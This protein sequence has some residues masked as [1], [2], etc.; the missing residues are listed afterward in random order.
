MRQIV[1]R[2]IALGIIT[3]WAV[4]TI[5]F[6]ATLALPGD[7][8]QAILGREA[9]DSQRLETL[10][11]RLGLNK[12]P[13][14][15]YGEWFAGVVRF[16]LG[17]SLTSGRPV[18]DVLG[19]RVMNS[20]VLAIGAAVTGTPLALVLGAL[21]AVKRGRTV[22]HAGSLVA[23][24]LAALPEFVIGIVL[25]LVF[26]IGLLQVLPAVSLVTPG[27]SPLSRP[28]IL[29]L[30][31]FT[32]VLATMPH[33]VRMVRAT[34]IDVLEADY[35]EMAR[36]KGLREGRIRWRHALPNA[37]APVVQIVALQWAWFAGGIV[38]TE[39]VFAYPGIGTA[40]IEAVAY[41]DIPVIQALALLIAVIYVAVNLVA[42]LIA[43]AT[44][45][46]ARTG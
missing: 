32:L 1:T 36:L 16:D 19:D 22:D 40:F 33:V 11:N 14:E 37:I 30:P 20:L 9:V 35:I 45:P 42:D 44:S 43:L 41:R 38:V 46:P 2:R 5:V 8:A 6:F 26:A 29:V 34:M 4:S 17:D 25:I 13:V 28:E 3:L 18:A 12:P 21:F 15:R 31:T 10:R 24:I 27:T 23:L 7:T 39:Y